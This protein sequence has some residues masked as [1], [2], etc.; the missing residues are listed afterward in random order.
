VSVIGKLFLGLIALV[1]A[2]SDLA[3]LGLLWLLMEYSEL[4]GERKGYAGMGLIKVMGLA[5]L[6][7]VPGA[8]LALSATIIT[9]QRRR[10]NGGEGWTASLVFFGASTALSLLL[11]AVCVL[12]D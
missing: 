1:V 6:L 8:L 4:S 7:I 9:I 5:L 3:Q 2:A 11:I 12:I 10:A